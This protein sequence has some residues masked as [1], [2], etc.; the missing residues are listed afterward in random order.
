MPPKPIADD[1]MEGVDEAEVPV[2]GPK[3]ILRL[4]EDVINQI[5]A[6]EVGPCLRVV[7]LTTCGV[8]TQAIHHPYFS[9]FHRA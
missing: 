3:P 1:P 5:A 2:D 7:F 4:S 8:S 9:P 6:A